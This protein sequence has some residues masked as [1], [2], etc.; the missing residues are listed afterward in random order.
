MIN[1]RHFFKYDSTTR[2]VLFIVVVSACLIG[3]IV[4]Q[5]ILR[6][7]ILKVSFYDIGQGDSIFIETPDRFQVLFDG[8]PGPAILERLSGDMPFYDRSLNLLVSTH[9]DAD[10][11]SGLIDVL[12]RYQVASVIT[13]S[14]GTRTSAYERFTQEL[15]YERTNIRQGMA[16]SDKD[17]ILLGGGVAL[18][19]LHPDAGTPTTN[20]NDSGIVS[21]VTYGKFNVLLLADVSKEVEKHILPWITNQV[22]VVKIAHHGSRFSSGKEF[23]SRIAPQICVIQVGKNTYGHPSLEALASITQAGCQL[24]RTDRQG[25][26]TLYSDGNSYWVK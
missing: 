11:I 9:P 1:V 16:F 12:E 4:L 14:V 22:T 15:G 3:G 5:G 19:I 7:R 21:L 18:T 17:P 6:P 8:G 25:T 20:T 23:L 13:S 24:W 10:H 26:L 2:R